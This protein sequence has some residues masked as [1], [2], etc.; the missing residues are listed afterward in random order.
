MLI[1]TC[2]GDRVDTDHSL[3]DLHCLHFVS[4]FCSHPTKYNTISKFILEYNGVAPDSS[5]SSG[6]YFDL[7]LR[8]A[9]SLLAIA[10]LKNRDLVLWLILLLQFHKT[11]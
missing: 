5:L 6:F 7:N 8:C 2:C 4:I 10:L 1:T 3:K 11:P 9:H